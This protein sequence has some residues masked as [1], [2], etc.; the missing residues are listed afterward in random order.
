MVETTACGTFWFC[1][2]NIAFPC[3]TEQIY[4]SND[5]PK[6]PSF[7]LFAVILLLAVDCMSRQM[8]EVGFM[9]FFRFQ[10]FPLRLCENIITITRSKTYPR[11][12]SFF[13]SNNGSL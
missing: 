1:R 3:Q 13:G 11:K 9:I 5:I 7:K 6:R 2:A 10:A 8:P 4:M 12:Y